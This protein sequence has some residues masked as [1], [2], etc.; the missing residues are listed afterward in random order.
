MNNYSG[1]SQH[2]RFQCMKKQ[3]NFCSRKALQM[4]RSRKKQDFRLSGDPNNQRTVPECKKYKHFPSHCVWN[5]AKGRHSF[6]V[7]KSQQIN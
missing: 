1:K 5:I 7:N 3:R 6:N 2:L 4:S